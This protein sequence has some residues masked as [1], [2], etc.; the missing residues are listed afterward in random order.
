MNKGKHCTFVFLLAGVTNLSSFS[1]NGEREH[2][3]GENIRDSVRQIEIIGAVTHKRK[4]LPGSTVKV[5]EGQE[6]LLQEKLGSDGKFVIHLEVEKMFRVEISN[7]QYHAKVFRMA[8]HTW[9]SKEDLYPVEM[10][11][12]LFA[13]EELKKIRNPE[14]ITA[15]TTLYYNPQAGYFQNNEPRVFALKER[16]HVLKER[17]KK[18]RI[19]EEKKRKKQLSSSQMKLLKSRPD[20]LSKYNS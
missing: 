20:R 9:N 2:Q 13:P 11:V 12:D 10:F 7:P 18:R 8:T 17:L 4:Q 14:K 15:I 6:L 16:F 5:Y 19:A 1:A 3:A